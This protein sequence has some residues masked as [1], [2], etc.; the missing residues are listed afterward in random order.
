MIRRYKVWWN[1]CHNIPG[2]NSCFS[3]C[4]LLGKYNSL[5]L[6]F[7]CLY[8]REMRVFYPVPAWNSNASNIGFDYWWNIKM[9]SFSFSFYSFSISVFL[10]QFMAWM[11]SKNHQLSRCSIAMVITL[12]IIWIFKCCDLYSTSRKVLHQI[13]PTDEFIIECSILKLLP[14]NAQF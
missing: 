7:V 5:F 10:I 12:S 1:A 9:L 6:L 11:Q 13:Q 8:S 14:C 3:S 2:W 4:W